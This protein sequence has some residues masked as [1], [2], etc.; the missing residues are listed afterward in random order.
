MFGKPEWFRKKKIGWG[1]T[2]ITWQGWVYALTWAAVLT[3][4]FTLLVMRHQ[5]VE[6]MV[7]LAA[8][9]GL[10]IYDVRHVLASMKPPAPVDDVLY[11]GD[12]EPARERWATR[13]YDFQLRN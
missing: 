1:L 4:P 5:A 3:L 7:W 13:N 9:S 11:I 10:L 6:A 12:E 8:A 2:P